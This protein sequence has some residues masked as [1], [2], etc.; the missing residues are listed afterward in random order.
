LLNCNDCASKTCIIQ[1]SCAGT[2]L[3]FA[4]E[5]KKMTTYSEGQ[6]ILLEGTSSRGI[7]L[8]LDGVAKIYK[9]DRQG[10]ELILRF[11]KSGDILGFYSVDQD[12]DS[13]V[14]SMAISDTTICQLSRTDFDMLLKL[15]PTLVQ[16]LLRFFRKEQSDV[17]SK[18]LKLAT[19]NVPHKV[20]DA[21]ITM[22]EALG[23][24]E[25]TDVLKLS[26]SRQD[27]ANLAGTTKEQVSK[28]LSAFKAEG[29]IITKAREIRIKDLN[30]L[31]AM[32]DTG[33]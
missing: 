2:A 15:Q 6:R 12:M 17:E 24:D 22:F 4:S 29:I 32:V 21:L 9:S 11:V 19:L 28:A 1:Q 18:S 26:L 31:R 20:A 10:R 14:S 8:V 3:D 30:A 27:I 23:A 5:R 33:G 7:Y 25:K 16:E 13:P